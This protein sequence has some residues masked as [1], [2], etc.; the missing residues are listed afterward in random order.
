[1]PK[2]KWPVLVVLLVAAVVIRFV[3]RSS[4]GDGAPEPPPELPRR[5]S[6]AQVDGGAPR[7]PERDGIV[8]AGQMPPEDAVH[9][10][11]RPRLHAGDFAKYL[12]LS[13]GA[14]T[15]ALWTGAGLEVYE[16]ADGT[17]ERT[18]VLELPSSAV[19]TMTRDGTRIAIVS[20]AALVVFGRAE[21]GWIE[22][23]RVEPRERLAHFTRP[24]ISYDGS[25][26]LAGRH[27]FE[28]R[29]RS[30][31]ARLRNAAEPNHRSNILAIAQDGRRGA[32]CSTEQD[33]PDRVEVFDVRGGSIASTSMEGRCVGL[34]LSGDGATVTIAAADMEGADPSTSETHL[35]A[36]RV[37]QRTLMADRWRL[38]EIDYG[39]AL[40]GA[41]DGT[42]LV[43]SLRTACLY[44]EDRAAIACA[45]N[46]HPFTLFEGAALAPDGAAWAIRSPEGVVLVMDRVARRSERVNAPA[47]EGAEAGRSE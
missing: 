7:A 6:E 14:H 32:Q 10:I 40:H 21:S 12:R 22:E 18:G 41:D 11:G 31:R 46:R 30:W 29:G 15:L 33:G 39:W 47:E 38:S 28:R 25:V 8:W 35:I 24:A 34:V 43:H 20:D 16:R 17:Y 42:L 19:F 4:R 36:Y 45:E 37:Q 9:R 26:V 2:R 1:M 3:L 44:G 23:A 13:D 5:A 27:V